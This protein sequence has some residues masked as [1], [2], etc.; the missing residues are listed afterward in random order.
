MRVAKAPERAVLRSSGYRCSAAYRRVSD[1]AAQRQLGY[2]PSGGL[3][4][5]LMALVVLMVLGRI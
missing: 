1:M 2:F 5:L 3:G 4:L